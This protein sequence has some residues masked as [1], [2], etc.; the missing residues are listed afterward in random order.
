M[1]VV[2]EVLYKNCLY[3]I[4]MHNIYIYYLFYLFTLEGVLFLL[5]LYDIL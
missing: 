4:E 2:S 1:N 3:L 5:Y